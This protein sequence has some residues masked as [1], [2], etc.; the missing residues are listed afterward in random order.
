MAIT[1]STPDQYTLGGISAPRSGVAEAFQA[2]VSANLGRQT[3]RQQM[4]EREQA[5]QLRAIEE[6]R[7]AQQFEMGLQDRA[8]AQARAA[9]AA[10]QEETRRRLLAQ[11]GGALVGGAPGLVTGA[12][13]VGV[14]PPAAPTTPTSPTGLRL[15]LDMGTPVGGGTDTLAGGAGTDVLGMY[16]MVSPEGLQIPGAAPIGPTGPAVSPE[17]LQL[18]TPA[19]ARSFMTPESMAA[20][21]GMAGTLAGYGVGTQPTRTRYYGVDFDVYPDGRIVNLATNTEIPATPEFSDL[22]SAVQSMASGDPTQM[23]TPQGVRPETGQ[24]LPAG[25]D[26]PGLYTA[27]RGDFPGAARAD[28]Y[29]AEGLINDLE[30]QQ[31]TRGTR[32]Q[33]AD[34]ITNVVRRRNAGEQAP[35]AP[36]APSPSVDVQITGPTGEETTVTVDEGPTYSFGAGLREPGA[37]S[38]IDYVLGQPVGSGAAAPDIPREPP[39]ISAAITQ[40]FSERERLVEAYNAFTQAGLLADAQNF[41]QAIQNLDQTLIRLQGEQAINDLQIGSVDRASQL[42][43]YYYGA[44]VQ[45]V[46]NSEGMYD[47]YVNGQPAE[48]DDFIDLRPDQMGDLLRPFFDEQYRGA[49]AE[50]REKYLTSRAEEQARRDMAEDENPGF[51][52]DRTLT[53]ANGETYMVLTNPDGEFRFV[54]FELDANNNP[55]T[56]TRALTQEDIENMG[57]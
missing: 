9:R 35:P 34:V 7:R 8:A 56:R 57:L 43:S 26:A 32:A 6:Q 33:Q 55:V 39:R 41:L 49:M 47:L 54:W 14:R 18:P 36:T 2:G 13:G 22:R 25:V 52:V 24:E 30:Y 3:T 50:G 12:P 21:A 19:P 15:P 27:L 4:Q 1:Y 10:A 5:M 29:L 46:L 40:G 51:T 16:P 44:D 38:P 45:P 48:N 17:G 37:G 23:M 42:L 11:Y 31:L 53:G 20:R 28:E